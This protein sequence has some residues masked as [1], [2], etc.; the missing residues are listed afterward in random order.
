MKRGHSRRTLMPLYLCTSGLLFVWVVFSTE[1][2]LNQNVTD[3]WEQNSDELYQMRGVYITGKRAV[4]IDDYPFPDETEIP[5]QQSILRRALIPFERH[6]VPYILGVSPLLMARKG[7][8]QQQ[9]DFLNSIVIHGFV[10]MH[11]FDHRTTFG[12]DAVNTSIWGIGGEF[13]KY[14]KKELHQKWHEGNKILS[15]VNKY[16]TEHFIPPFNAITQDMVDILVHHGVK[17]IHTMDAALRNKLP[18]TKSHPAVGGNFGGWIEDFKIPQGIKFVVSE[19]Q[20]SYTQITS[21]I[22][23][24]LPESQITLHWFYDSRLEDWQRLY[25]ELALKLSQTL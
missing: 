4:R 20:T 6:S 9:I 17:Y 14:T 23:V 25:E 15:K 19:W 7:S 10:C 1:G 16:T 8:L 24:S 22:N 5:R 18:S 12:K 21:F 3:V 13:A 11:G 2:F